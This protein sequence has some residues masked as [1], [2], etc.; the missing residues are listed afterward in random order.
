[1]LS[2]GAKYEVVPGNSTGCGELAQS[3]R[4]TRRAPSCAATSQLTPL[5]CTL[6][7]SLKGTPP[8]P[9]NASWSGCAPLRHDQNCPSSDSSVSPKMS[10][11]KGG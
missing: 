5:G 3:T 8:A 2:K 11:G 4:N 10:R 9:V 6:V 7:A 1:M